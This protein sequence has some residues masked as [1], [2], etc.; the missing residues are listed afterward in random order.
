VANSSRC[1]GK[2]ATL[3]VQGRS[4]QKKQAQTRTVQR[5]ILL[6]NVSTHI[7]RSWGYLQDALERHCSLQLTNR[8]SIDRVACVARVARFGKFNCAGSAR[9]TLQHQFTIVHVHLCSPLVWPIQEAAL[10]GLR[11]GPEKADRPLCR[12]HCSQTGHRKQAGR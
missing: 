11:D 12:A 3:S 10:R 5:H 1:C 8:R 4:T 6:P 2:Q 9:P 7:K